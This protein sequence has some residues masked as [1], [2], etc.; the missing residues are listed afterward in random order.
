MTTSKRFS[1]VAT[2]SFLIAGI[3]VS[4]IFA[5]AIPSFAHAATY[6]YVNTSGNVSTVTANDWQTALATAQNIGLHSGV[7]LLVSQLDF[8]IVGNT[9]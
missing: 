6:A 4:S 3:A 9:I 1:S 2:R 7:M 8:N 5:M